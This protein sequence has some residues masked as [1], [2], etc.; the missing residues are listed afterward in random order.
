MAPPPVSSAAERM[1]MLKSGSS[2]PKCRQ[3]RAWRSMLA[4][5]AHCSSLASWKCAASSFFGTIHNEKGLSAAKGT[6]QRKWSDSSTTRWRPSEAS[7]RCRS[8][9]S[10]VCWKTFSWNRWRHSRAC[11]CRVA[12]SI[13]TMGKPRICECGWWSDAP[14][15]VPLFLKYIMCLSV[16]S[17]CSMARPRLRKALTTSSTCSAGCSASGRLCCGVSISTSWKPMASTRSVSW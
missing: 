16:A 13:G 14:A 11:R 2:S 10:S 3:R 6:K 4:N 15:L 12:T 7:S 17:E 1:S 5:A 8:V 9:S